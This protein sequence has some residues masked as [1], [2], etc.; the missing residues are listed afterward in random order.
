M[1]YSM[2]C[3]WQSCSLSQRVLNLAWSVSYSM[4]TAHLRQLFL[5]SLPCNLR[6]NCVILRLG[7]WQL[8]LKAVRQL[9]TN[10]KE[11]K[12]Y[13]GLSF[14]WTRY[15]IQGFLL[16]KCRICIYRS[17]LALQGECQSLRLVTNKSTYKRNSLSYSIFS[18]LKRNHLCTYTLWFLAIAIAPQREWCGVDI[19]SSLRRVRKQ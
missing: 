9:K 3:C 11:L 1:L 18:K 8:L 10:F 2:Y 7:Y 4:I 12:L 15:F 16:I 13:L 6:W 14:N 19:L 5:L 17:S